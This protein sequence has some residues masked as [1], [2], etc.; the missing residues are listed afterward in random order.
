MRTAR[1]A[2]SAKKAA[3]R[4]RTARA[5]STNACMLVWK[6][7]IQFETFSYLP[8]L[9]DDDIKKQIA[10]MLR[11]GLTPCLEF[12][13]ADGDQVLQE[14]ANCKKEYPDHY[15]RVVGFNAEKQVQMAPSSCTSRSK[16]IIARLALLA[17]LLARDGR[18]KKRRLTYVQKWGPKRPGRL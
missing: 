9:S 15:I 18:V 16:R 1:P 11:K 12:G 4:G 6:P 17:R 14:V 7:R 8:P 13:C 3:T 10:Y 2:R 5:V